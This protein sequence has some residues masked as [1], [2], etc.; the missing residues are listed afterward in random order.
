[1]ER[2]R[3]SERE[4]LH[5]GDSLEDDVAGAKRSGTWSAWL[6]RERKS[7]ETGI[8]PDFELSSLPELADLC[9]GRA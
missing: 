4:L 1:M 7:N 5:V 2:A 3:C 9:K 8:E 6:N